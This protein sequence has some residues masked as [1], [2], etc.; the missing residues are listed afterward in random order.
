MTDRQLKQIMSL[1]HRV[2]TFQHEMELFL[3]ACD[4]TKF[5]TCK[6]GLH[7]LNRIRFAASGLRIEIFL[8]NPCEPAGGTLPRPIGL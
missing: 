1:A 3:S 2:R 4:P 7:S 6:P 8:P 5:E